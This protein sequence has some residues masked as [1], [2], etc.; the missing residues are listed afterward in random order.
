MQAEAPELLVH[1]VNVW[2]EKNPR[3]YFIRGM[4]DCARAFLSDRYRVIDHLDVLMY[5]LKELQVH[6]AEVED[7]FLSEIEMNIK[8]KSQKLRDFVRHKDDLIIGGLYLTNSETGDKVLRV[9][10]QLFRDKF[11]NGMIIEEFITWRFILGT[12]TSCMMK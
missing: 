8:V 6:E 5:A 9:E 4:E 3:N 10:H 11:S 2:L 7:C 12:T 1:N